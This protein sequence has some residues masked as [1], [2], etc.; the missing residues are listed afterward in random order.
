MAVTSN[1]NQSL[2]GLSTPDAFFSNNEMSG[3]QNGRDGTKGTTPACV[4]I[5]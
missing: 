3:E 4:I 5:N 2:L 1:L